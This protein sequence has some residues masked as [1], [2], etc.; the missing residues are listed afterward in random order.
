MADAS[1]VK[2]RYLIPEVVQTSAM[3]CGPAALKALFGGFNTYLSYGRLREACQT[4]VDG[5]SIDTIEVI[6]GQLGMASTQ[7]MLPADL[8]LLE[9][10]ACLP[11]IVVTLS[12]EATHFVVLWRV[13]GPWVQVMDPA[14]GRM[15]MSRQR[16]LKSLYVHE[17][18]VPAE[19]WH[20]WSQSDVFTA[21][22][23]D[24]MRGLGVP[25]A[26]W[27]DRAQQD[28][29]LRLAGTLR[30]NGK[31]RSGLET[32]R[33]LELCKDHSADI[34]EEFWTVRAHPQD[35]QQLIM[36]GA[37]LLS[38]G[39]RVVEPDDDAIPLSLQR[40]RSEAEPNIWGV[41]WTV[42]RESG[43][44]LPAMTAI[45]VSA[46]AFGTV[47]E[48]L[49]FRGLF[50]MGRH[51][52]STAERFA[53]IAA[54]LIFLSTVLAL[55]WPASLGL[56]RIG[57]QFELGLRAR[58]LMKVPLLSDRYF[59]SRL[60]SDM[61]FRAHWLQLLRQLPDT[62]GHVLSLVTSILVTALAIA[63]VY[64][65]TALLVAVAAV[66]ACVIPLLI[67]P[68]MGERDL[69]FREI[70][71]SLGTFYLDALLG[72]R[73]V[74]AH[75]AERSM[76]AAHAGQ[77][78]QWAAAGLRQQAL[79]VRAETLQMALT[80]GFAIVMV[81]RQ[82]ALSQSPA[83]LLLLIYWSI[84]I[85][86]LGKEVAAVVRS[87]PAM[88][89]TLL[90]FLELIGS[91]EEETGVSEGT[92]SGGGVEI[93]LQDVTVMMAGRKVLE[94]VTLHIASGEH[95]GIVGVSG[96][97]KSSLVGCLLG[98][99]PPSTGSVQIDGAPLDAARLKG[100]RRSTAWIDPQVHLF[101]SSL[102][103]NLRYGNGATPATS[104]EDAIAVADLDDVLRRSSDGLQTAVAEG[105][106][107]LSGGEGQR[108]R[109][110]RAFG[111][112]GVRLAILDEP[113]R[114]LGR[115]QRSRL[116]INARQRFAHAT[117]LCITH[118][119]SDTLDFD[120]VLVIENGRIVEQGPPQMLRAVPGSRYEQ[121]LTEEYAV[122]R[123]LWGHTK[124]R[125]WR[126]THGALTESTSACS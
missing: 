65:G 22:L 106:A 24:R 87:L 10:S 14:A 28:A 105:G 72:S 96:A 85:P 80:F 49:L 97:G 125:R 33:L 77:L 70:S 75:G 113:A 67:L 23:E 30:E 31:L 19:A 3:D 82:A 42:L 18:A 8:L 35:S 21:G 61:A 66:A 122:G 6:A 95:V 100:L 1:A 93:D 89:N 90:R 99:H 20:Q 50:D 25:A 78:R 101:R 124:W 79:F 115:E 123:E 126:L 119:V 34:P 4:D 94:N 37:V 91:P 11:A 5:T 45:G 52:Q 63:W 27:P 57:R 41:A 54:L 56:S 92:I 46:A 86:A 26:V 84:G 74:Q 103:E 60:I 55:D 109:A 98:W 120:R 108:L 58:F 48:A 69:R 2:R 73:A 15:W 40:V 68:A 12:S 53:A 102:Y 83:G 43:W 44:L 81:Y 51:L 38:A 104:I 76:R 9:R 32:R 118:D 117:L 17:H 36:R 16:F 88:R 13:H 121:L 59:Q 112:P 7:S 110:A 107:S 47:I 71:A 39:N 114:G 116:L 64:P 62:V 29:A 111:R